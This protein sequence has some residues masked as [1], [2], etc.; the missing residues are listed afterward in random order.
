MTEQPKPKCDI[1]DLLCQLQIINHL[2]GM[3]NLLGTESFWVKY[4]EFEG[5]EETVAERIIEQKF[6]LKEA[7]EKC[8]MPVPEEEEITTVEE[9]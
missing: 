1:D 7:F 3:K 2:E 9:E 4:P 5:L 8:G 6:T